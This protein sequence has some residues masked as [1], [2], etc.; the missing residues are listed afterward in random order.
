MSTAM[1]VV[2]PF[3]VKTVLPL[4]KN[5][6]ERKKWVCAKNSKSA[7]SVVKCTSI[8]RKRSMC[9]ENIV[10][11]TADRW[12]K[13]PLCCAEYQV[14][15]KKPHK[16]YHA[17]CRNCREFMHVA[18]CCYIQPIVEAPPK[19][20]DDP[21]DDPMNFNDDDDNDEDK[22]GPPP[23]S[24]LEFCRYRMCNLRG[25]P[26]STEPHLLVQWRGWE[27][28]SWKNHWRTLRSLWGTY[29]RPRK[30]ITFFHNL[31]G[32]DGNF[33]LEALYDQGRAVERPWKRRPHF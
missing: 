9:A 28:S 24:C 29:E 25:S 16:C 32:F 6:K 10:A 15:P 21:F 22:R 1:I 17:T 13:C 18:H 11:P 30:V 26:L 27:D 19:Q 20:Q 2:G 14:I 4:T 5:L 8:Q 23:P 7:R 33:I 12:K 3:T 31:R